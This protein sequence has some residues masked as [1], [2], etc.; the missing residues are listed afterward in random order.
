M[1]D[2][3]LNIDLNGLVSEKIIKEI[4]YLENRIEEQH[5]EISKLKSE[6]TKLENENK[7]ILKNEIF[8]DD[9]INNFKNIKTKNEK[10]EVISHLLKCFYNIDFNKNIEL[11]NFSYLKNEAS[12]DNMLAISFYENKNELIKIMNMLSLNTKI[13]ENFCMPYDYSKEIIKKYASSSFCNTNGEY[14]F[15]RY[16]LSSGANLVNVPHT[17]L[18]KNKYFLDDDI[19]DKIINYEHSSSIYYT[20][21][22]IYN[23]NISDIQINKL[24]K[25]FITSYKKYID[26]DEFKNFFKRNILRLDN[27]IIDKLFLSASHENKY[28]FLY[29]EMFPKEYQNIYLLKIEN[30]TLFLQ[31][32]QNN[33]KLDN[34]EKINLTKQYMGLFS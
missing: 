32:L 16:W 13:V 21:L 24:A 3:I 22:D 7:K 30:Y 26:T 9:L 4:E 29:Y 31:L 25:F 33:E 18:F 19:L 28:R 23:E 10:F 15:W 8:V 27:E 11:E 6:I 17:L 34:Q 1:E 20:N 5:I 2:N 12:L 14:K